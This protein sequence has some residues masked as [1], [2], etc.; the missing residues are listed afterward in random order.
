MAPV[1]TSCHTST[2]PLT[3]VCYQDLSSCAVSLQLP[4]HYHSPGSP[5][6]PQP[7]HCMYKQMLHGLPSLL[8]S[9]V[10]R[11]P[12]EGGKKG[13]RACL[14]VVHWTLICSLTLCTPL[15]L[16]SLLVS[17]CKLFQPAATLSQAS[18]S[19]FPALWAFC[20]ALQ[21]SPTFSTSL[22]PYL[23]QPPFLVP[24]QSSI[25][26]PPPPPCVSYALVQATV[27]VGTVIILYI[28]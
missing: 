24:L 4:Q 19:P 15:H 9:G 6:L 3:V 11:A 12:R 14:S 20:I 16:S 10:A 1:W 17:L 5:F 27:G 2:C 8:L 28:I 13:G 23:L 18:P 25:L 26:L 21:P 7:S 22:Q